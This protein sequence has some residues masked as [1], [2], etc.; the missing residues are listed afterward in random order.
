MSRNTNRYDGVVTSSDESNVLWDVTES[1]SMQS[2]EMPSTSSPPTASPPPFADNDA[3]SLYFDGI[4]TS[5]FVNVSG[6]TDLDFDQEV[7]FE[8]WIKP[9]HFGEQQIVAMRT[10]GDYSGWSVAIMCPAGAGPAGSGCCGDHVDGALGFVART[11]TSSDCIA[12]KSAKTPLRLGEWQHVAVA[13]EAP[14]S[15]LRSVSFYVDG[16]NVGRFYSSD[17]GP[18]SPIQLKIPP[19]DIQ[20]SGLSLG[21]GVCGSLDDLEG[22]HG[23][24]A[25][26]CRHFRGWIDGFKLWSAALSDTTIEAHYDKDII[27]WHVNRDELVFYYKFDAKSGLLISPNAGSSSLT[28]V[29]DPPEKEALIWD[30]ANDYPSRGSDFSAPPPPAPPSQSPRQGTSVLYF[31]GKDTNVAAAHASS[32]IPGQ[33]LTF[34]AW[35]RPLD[36]H[37][38]QVLAMMGANGWA[39]M[40]TCSEGSGRACCGTDETHAPGT[41]MFWTMENTP[42]HATQNCRDAPTS[43][44]RVLR[45]TWQHVAVVADDDDQS[46]QF[47]IDGEDAGR[48]EN[49]RFD[50]SLIN[51]GGAGSALQLGRSGACRCLQYKGYMDE[52]SLWNASITAEN[53]Y[54]HHRIAP[55]E[56][57]DDF[58]ELVAYWKF[59][60]AGMDS[61]G[62]LR[63]EFNKEPNITIVDSSDPDDVLWDA[64]RNVDVSATY[65]KSN[66]TSAP[67][68]PQ[69]GP[70]ALRFNGYD[71]QVA[72]NISGS[73]PDLTDH[74]APEDALTFEAWV[75]PSRVDKTQFIASSKITDGASLMCNAATGTTCCGDHVDGAIG[76]WTHSAPDRDNCAN[77]ISSDDGL[78]EGDGST[79]RWSLNWRVTTFGVIRLTD[80]SSFT[81]TACPRDQETSPDDTE[82]IRILNGTDATELYFG[83]FGACSACTTTV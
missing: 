37:R 49:V 64:G 46:V 42:M 59:D 27:D 30:N 69:T 73:S 36:L 77:T 60:E 16:V 4:D 74:F 3:S 29:L 75:R 12:A 6:S 41:L 61:N 44:R 68:P 45:D 10:G 11:M 31:N 43:T 58:D 63:S 5:A 2:F 18:H 67:P 66:R 39:L 55:S 1:A 38:G 53:I 50:E 20:N 82:T 52:V 8:A 24:L 72:V 51:D 79:S 80:P 28:M 22:K 65:Q 47:Y 32:M 56:W 33:K 54:E 71:T 40:L 15:G 19:S 26:H 13:V 21:R 23:N 83:R 57:H 62:V 34:Q 81:L 14:Q 9:E 7:T 70:S 76:F 17:E 78:V 35:I 48:T 25:Y